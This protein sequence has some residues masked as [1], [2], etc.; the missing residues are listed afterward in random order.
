MYPEDLY[1]YRPTSNIPFL[2]TMIKEAVAL[3]FHTQIVL[4]LQWSLF[5]TI[6][7]HDFIM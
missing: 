3:Q 7:S 2:S 4:N 5:I 6:A 1:N